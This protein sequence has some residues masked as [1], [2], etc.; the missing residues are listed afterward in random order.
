MASVY[1]NCVENCVHLNVRAYAP[2][3]MHHVQRARASGHVIFERDIHTGWV[4]T[5]VF[6]CVCVYILLTRGIDHG[7]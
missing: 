7:T 3:S 6:V 5:S 4:M 1:L 2:S